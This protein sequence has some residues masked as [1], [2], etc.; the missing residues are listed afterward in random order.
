MKVTIITLYD[1]REAAH[2]VAVVEGTVSEEDFRKLAVDLGAAAE[3]TPEYKASLDDDEP[4]Q[5]FKVEMDTYPTVSAV[6]SVK[7]LY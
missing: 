5:L 6:K 7:A 4:R 2:L 1:G 3:G